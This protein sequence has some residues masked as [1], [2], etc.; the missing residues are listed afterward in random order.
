[1]R[2]TFFSFLIHK[3]QCSD[4]DRYESVM[5][6]EADLA[7]LIDVTQELFPIEFA[8]KLFIAVLEVYAFANAFVLY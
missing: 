8:T 7:T 5:N 1:M 6:Y 4:L 3:T 2:N